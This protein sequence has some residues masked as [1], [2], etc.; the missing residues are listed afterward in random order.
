MEFFNSLDDTSDRYK[1]I[2]RRWICS[3]KIVPKE[4]KFLEICG[5]KN[6]L[7]ATITTSKD[8]PKGTYWIIL[9]PG[10]CAGGLLMLLTVSDC[11]K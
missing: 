11:E 2:K 7:K 9:T 1:E 10:N 3:R 4:T 5:L 6:T 8:V